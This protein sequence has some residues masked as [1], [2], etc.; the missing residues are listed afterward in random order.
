MGE[1]PP[2]GTPTRVRTP[3]NDARRNVSTAASPR[4]RAK[5]SGNTLCRNITIYGWCR[6]E[7]KGCAFNH[8]PQ[9]QKTNGS[10][11]RGKFNV[12]SPS[13]TPQ[14]PP[15]NVMSPKA[16]DAAPFTPKGAAPPPVQPNFHDAV[17][18]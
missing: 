18:K 7:G 11:G 17:S 14:T 8:D 3:P 13:F 5:D 6:F 12:E 15:R 10:L 9:S 16:A 4:P 1:R 2:T